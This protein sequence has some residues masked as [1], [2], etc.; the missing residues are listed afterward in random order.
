MLPSDDNYDSLQSRLTVQPPYYAFNCVYADAHSD[1]IYGDFIPEQPVV[2]EHA[3]ISVAEAGRHVA[4]LGTLLGESLTTGNGPSYYLAVEA[5][6]SGA[7]EPVLH[8]QPGEAMTAYVRCRENTANRLTVDGKL[9]YKN[10]ALLIFVVS[11]VRLGET[12]FRFLYRDSAMP[13]GTA[14]MPVMSPWRHPVP[15]SMLPEMHQGKL[16]AKINSHNPQL[17]A[18]HF[19]N[20][21][22]WPVAIVMSAATQLI[23]TLLRQTFYSELQYRIISAN[24]RAKKLLSVTEAIIFHAEII[25]HQAGDVNV[26]C[27]ISRNDSTSEQIAELQVNLIIHDRKECAMNNFDDDFFLFLSNINPEISATDNED[28]T[29]FVSTF[30]QD[31]VDALTVLTE[32]EKEYGIR[33]PDSDFANMDKMTL[34][35][36]CDIVRSMTSGTA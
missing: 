16:S 8:A 15:L 19:E 32:I 22:M 9:L 14:V 11:Y 12:Q 1:G 26:R 35:G 2:G 5:D 17:C 28:R 7:D 25:N 18:G 29:M 20:Y 33:V 21:P 6:V 4:I 27:L 3:A 24:M 36:L 31:S 30:W 10:K 23:T 34:Q 13:T